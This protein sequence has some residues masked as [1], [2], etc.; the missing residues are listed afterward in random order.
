MEDLLHGFIHEAWV[1]AIDFTTLERVSGS[2]VSDALRDREDGIVWRARWGT[3]WLYLYVLLG[4]QSTVD[5]YMAWPCA[6]WSTLACYTV[7]GYRSHC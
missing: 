1:Q 3:D 4:F 7:H 5:P 2:Y 6:C